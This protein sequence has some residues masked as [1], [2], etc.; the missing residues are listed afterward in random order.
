MVS[1]IGSSSKL[2]FSGRLSK[3]SSR[4]RLARDAN[5]VTK[6]KTRP[7]KDGGKGSNGVQPNS[8]KGSLSS[9]DF[10]CL[11]DLNLLIKRSSP[12]PIGS[13]V[14]RKSGLV[15][16]A[17]LVKSHYKKMAKFW[18]ETTKGCYKERNGL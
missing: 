1:L 5:R 4:N 9:I 17:L 10:V 3:D 7:I 8:I 15:L 6:G 12:K 14:G 18:K 11:G 13:L 2:T 16:E